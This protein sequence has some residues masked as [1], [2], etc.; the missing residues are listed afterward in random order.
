MWFRLFGNRKLLILFTSF[1][2]VMVLIGVTGQE[3]SDLTWPEKVMKD[4]IAKVQGW[5]YKPAGVLASFVDD[6]SRIGS[7]YEE[8]TMLRAELNDHLQ[9]KAEIA[10]LKAKNKALENI[11]DYR[12]KSSEEY[13]TAQVVS[14]SIDRFNDMI[15]ID[16]GAHDGIQPNMAVITH[17]G[18]IGRVGSVT[19]RMASIQLLTSF[20]DSRLQRA[21]AI[22]AEVGEQ[23]AFGIIEGYD[24]ER[25]A[26]LLT[27]VDKDV[28]LEKGDQVVT[29]GQSEIYPPNL[30]IGEVM[31][32]GTG[33]YGLDQTAYIKPTASFDQLR[34]VMVVRD[35]EKLKV[36]EHLKEIGREHQ[37]EEE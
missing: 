34:F 13:I 17:E 15:V 26:L 30:L 23:G 11:A 29:Y 9:L 20:H 32:T 4:S 7:L 14:R 16:R 27:M 33:R 5:L 2:L 24:F 1:I 37:S 35:P 25:E 19:D 36:Q 18:L 22:A 31:S 28:A 10:D 3:R 12:E 8:N 6:L 21:P